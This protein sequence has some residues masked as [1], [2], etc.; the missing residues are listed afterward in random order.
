M[1]TWLHGGYLEQEGTSDRKESPPSQVIAQ[2]AVFSFSFFYENTWHNLSG[3]LLHLFN[4]SSCLGSW[5]PVLRLYNC[6]AGTFGQ[7]GHSSQHRKWATPIVKQRKKHT[8]Q[9][10]YK[11]NLKIRL[12]KRNSLQGMFFRGWEFFELFYKIHNSYDFL[13]ALTWPS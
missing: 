4:I 11:H 5:Q 12:D 13:H 7:G 10:Y 1:Q 6:F 2:Y 3:C 8:N 9:W